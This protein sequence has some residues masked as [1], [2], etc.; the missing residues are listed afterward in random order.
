MNKSKPAAKPLSDRL[1][2]FISALVVIALIFAAGIPASAETAANTAA[3]PDDLDVVGS[4]ISGMSTT[5]IYGAPVTGSVFAQKELTVLHYF[6]TWS[7]DCIREM[8]YMQTALDDFGSSVIS[9]YGLLY[10]DGTSTPESCAALFQQLSLNY[11]CLRLDSVL[12]SLVTV[13]PYIPQTFLVN[14]SGI[15]VAHFPGTFSSV[16]E[17]EALI[18]HALGNPSLFHSVSFIDGLTGQ[19]IQRVTVADGASAVPPTPPAHAGHEFSHWDGNYQNVTEDRTVTAIYVPIG[20]HYQPGDVDMNGVIGT[21]DAIIALRHTIGIEWYE[22]V[23]LLGDMNGDGHITI[24]DVIIILR[25]AT[26]LITP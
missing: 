8:E 21:A 5:N 4:D 11:G 13:Y 15:V 18:A 14:S 7:Q 22:S 23:L 2:A 12:N 20:G 6:A 17:L 19:L 3:T 24:T 1:N 25:H 9:V 26:G 10:E 16:A